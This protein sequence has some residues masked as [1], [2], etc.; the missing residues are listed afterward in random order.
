[1]RCPRCESLSVL[2][3]IRYARGRTIYIYRCLGCARAFLVM[4]M[5]T[6][7]AETHA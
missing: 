1:M 5:S 6:N 2:D 3:A 7:E 4:R